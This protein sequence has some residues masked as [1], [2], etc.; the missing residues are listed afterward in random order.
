ML[1]E[2]MGPANLDDYHW[3]TGD[4]AA[5]WLDG[6]R[7]APAADVQQVAR[8]R[9]ELSAE[10]VHLLLEQTRLRQR[11]TA[12]FGHLAGRM[13]FTPVGLE[14][15]T[16]LAVASYK[17][18]RFPVASPVVDFCSGIGGDLMAL[19]QRG[20]TTGVDQDPVACHL[21]AANA[22]VLGEPS[23]CSSSESLTITVANVADC[24]M[25]GTSAWHIDPDRRPTGKR[26]TRVELH[27]PA[28]EVI[29]GLRSAC[30]HAAVKLAPAGVLPAHWAAEAEQE[31]ISRGGECRQLV[32][33]FAGLT[34][35]SGMR[36]ATLVDWA[37]PFD[38]AA[39]A[40]AGEPSQ[41]VQ[42]NFGT[43]VVLRTIVGQ[44]GE[45]VET[46]DAA[47][48]YLYEPDNAVLAADLRG[49]LAARHKLLG[50]DRQV[51]YLT[52]DTLLEDA[53]LAA[54]EV[55]DVMPFQ[56][57]RVRAWVRQHR[58]GTLEVKQRGTHNDANA[59]AKELAGDG[60]NRATLFVTRARGKV[61]AILARRVLSS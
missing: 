18:S 20:P 29:D 43:H 52:G 57:R 50:L 4:A 21:A 14:Q 59:L 55:L 2:Q 28:P 19:S 37:D 10:R 13:F 15:A 56:T 40:Q 35:R 48:R 22:A 45:P 32:A 53:A 31:W 42:P 8:L 26:T 27:Q 49:S 38:R 3:L 24:D 30:P 58:V 41:T 44:A 5:A 9:R 1:G 47:G 61:M 17:A 23:G 11:A 34:G 46:A 60:D 25:N 54:F 6:L 39:F 12:K 7:H 33:W 51:A 36:R 16:D